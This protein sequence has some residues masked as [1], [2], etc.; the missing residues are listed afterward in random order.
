MT[1]IKLVPNDEPNAEGEWVELRG[2]VEVHTTLRWRE[3]EIFLQTIGVVPEGMHVV[4][5]DHG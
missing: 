5:I 3:L 4:S 2:S 1:R